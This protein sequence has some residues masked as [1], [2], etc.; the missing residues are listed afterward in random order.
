M[1]NVLEIPGFHYDAEKKRYFK[2]T[3]NATTKADQTYGRDEINKRAK[4]RDHQAKSLT[5]T[6]A[7]K[8]K[9][10]EYQFSISNPISTLFPSEKHDSILHRAAGYNLFRRDQEQQDFDTIQRDNVWSD[11]TPVLGSLAQTAIGLHCLPKVNGFLVVT[12]RMNVLFVSA[13][14]APVYIYQHSELSD[15][16]YESFRTHVNVN[17]LCITMRAKGTRCFY[18]LNIDI[19]S[20]SVPQVLGICVYPEASDEILDG[21]FVSGNCGAW[22]AYGGKILASE[23]VVDKSSDNRFTTSKRW[24]T[25][26]KSKSDVMCLEI[27]RSRLF[28]SMTPL[29]GWYGTRSGA[30]YTLSPYPTYKIL[31]SAK[32]GTFEGMSIVSVKNLDESH[33]LLSGLK[34]GSQP[35]AVVSKETQYDRSSSRPILLAFNSSINNLLRETEI[36]CTSTDGRFVLYGRRYLES[37]DGTLELFSTRAEDNLVHDTDQKSGL[38]TYYPIKTLRELFPSESLKS[39]KRLLHAELHEVKKGDNYFGEL[40]DVDKIRIAIFTNDSDVAGVSF[41]SSVVI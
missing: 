12:H 4:K 32:I 21:V 20:L 5:S 28:N 8:E 29:T 3:R 33:L 31:R 27:A 30:L 41:K 15:Y 1:D 39:F 19:G 7:K 34:C 35:L 9:L 36:L 25:V 18:V 14:T 23:D 10:R 2:I 6:R 16:E 37:M 11:L 26:E 38:K 24:R 17:Q 40:S 22:V 13:E